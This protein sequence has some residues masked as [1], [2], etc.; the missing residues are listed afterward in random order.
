MAKRLKF[1]EP[2]V[3]LM[4]CIILATIASY[5]VAAGK[6][7]RKLDPTTGQ[8]LAV[9]GSFKNV[10]SDPVGFFEMLVAIPKGMEQAGSVIFFIFLVGGA[11]VVISKTGA[12]NSLVEIVVDKLSGIE[13]LVIPISVILFATL[14]AIQNFHEEI[15]PLIPVLLILCKRLGFNNLTA[16]ILSLGAALVGSAFSPIN[17]FQV[18]IAQK[19]AGVELF[20]GA[21]FRIIILIIA[22][23]IYIF[24]VH[25]YVNNTKKEIVK[26]IKPDLIVFTL[27]HKMILLLLVLTFIV[28]VIGVWNWDWD[29]EQM[30]ALFFLTG[31]LAGYIGGLR[32][33][34]TVKAFIEGF[35]DMAYAGLLIG[36][37]RAIYVVLEDGLIVDSLVN[38]MFTPISQLPNSIALSGITVIQTLIHYPIPSVSGQAILTIPLLAP[39]ADLMGVSRQLMVLSYQY[40]AGL[41]DLIIPTNGAIMAILVAA[42][43]SFG[44]WIKFSIK[45]YGIMIILGLIAIY[46]AQ[47]IDF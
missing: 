35:K 24:L 12:L 30:S 38:G 36:F 27:A 20:S 17:P 13:M 4:V 32:T 44:Q 5:L 28:L 47:L 25:R 1:P 41:A 11:F 16:V 33:S 46:I 6:F 45:V 9:A 26:D 14:G 37:S 19:I 42:K 3:L 29:F 15:I 34:G 18:G 23:G 31:I 21:F 43:V 2:L 39:L 40:G 10:D 8:E 7:D 22:V